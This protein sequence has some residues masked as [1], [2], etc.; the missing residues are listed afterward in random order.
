MVSLVLALALAP[1]VL[2]VACVGDSI[3]FGYG[4]P[5]P[6][7]AKSSYPAALGFRLGGGYEVE[8]FGHTGATLMNLDW[9]P[10]IM[11]TDEYK[12]SL[13]F[14]PN[15]V[16]IMGGTNDGAPRNWEHASQLP[17]DLD[18]MVKSYHDLPSH[19]KI[20]ILIPPRLLPKAEG[21]LIGNDTQCDNVNRLLPP[22]LRAFATKQGLPV[23]DARQVITTRDCYTPDGIHLTEKGC[24]K[25]ANQVAFVLLKK[26]KQA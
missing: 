12:K 21:G 14:Q 23:I 1:P 5:E 8:N 11:K 4:L 26:K 10:P 6:V 19:P 13:E 9:L 22:I 25:L 7:R 16:L 2:K 18:K 15:I 3:T 17:T 20:Y 24:G